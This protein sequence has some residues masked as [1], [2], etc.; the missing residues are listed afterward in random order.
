ME[1][2][3]HANILTSLSVIISSQLAYKFQIP[4]HSRSTIRCEPIP[5]FWR[6]CGGRSKDISTPL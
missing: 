5:A 2:H 1:K 3:K 6:T 4:F